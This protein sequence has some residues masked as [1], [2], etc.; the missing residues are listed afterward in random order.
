MP[1]AMNEGGEYVLI[2]E[3]GQ[4][5]RF[6]FLGRDPDSGRLRLETDGEGREYADLEELAEGHYSALTEVKSRE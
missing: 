5:I 6:T 3:L 2:N 4:K 1:R